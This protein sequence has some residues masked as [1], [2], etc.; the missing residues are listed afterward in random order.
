[1]ANIFPH[2]VGKYRLS[3]DGDLYIDEFDVIRQNISTFFDEI[4][5][6]D[7]DSQTF[8]TRIPAVEIS[9]VLVNGQRLIRSQYEPVLPSSITIK[10]QLEGTEY[11][12]IIYRHFVVTPP[13]I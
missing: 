12:K 1:M 3:T 7:G 10:E 4:I 5:W 8:E 11:V 9:E 6:K 2:K 13:N